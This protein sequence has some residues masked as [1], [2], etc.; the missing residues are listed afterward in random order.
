MNTFRNVYWIGGSPCAGKTSIS[1]MLVEKYDFTLYRCDDYLDKHLKIG[2]KRNYPI[3]SKLCK[4]SCDEI[5]MRSIDIQVYEEFQYYREEFSLI[6]EELEEYSVEQTV[7]VEGT[8]VLPDAIEVL[9]IE[10][11]RV[12]FIVPSANFQLEHYIKRDFIP[13]VLEGCKNKDKAFEN[14][15]QRDMEFAKEIARQARLNQKTLIVTDGSNSLQENFK[16]VEDHF[17]LSDRVLPKG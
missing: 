16:R 2:A 10:K 14:W 13:Y 17:E 12:V 8:A 3:M 1:E 6:L 11:N 4:M 15:M 7:L 9:N 5:W